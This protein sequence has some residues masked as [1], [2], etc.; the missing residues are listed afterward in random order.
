[1]ILVFKMKPGLFI[2]MVNNYLEMSKVKALKVLSI[3]T[4][5]EII[6]MVV[7]PIQ[8]G[9]GQVLGPAGKLLFEI[10]TIPFIYYVAFLIFLSR[11]AKKKTEDQNIGLVIFF[12]VMPIVGLVYLLDLF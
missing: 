6:G 12:N 11:Y 7:W 3:I 9:W 1:M 4:V 10:F 2:F 8:I 5:I